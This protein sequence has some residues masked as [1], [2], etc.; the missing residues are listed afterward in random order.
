[1]IQAGD[2]IC[3]RG[4]GWL[5]DKIRALTRHIGE[6]RTQISHVAIGVD[7]DTVVE[8]LSKVRQGGLQTD[9][10]VAI[11]RPKGLT[12]DEIAVIVKDAK[13]YVGRSY[14]YIKIAAHALDWLLQGA[15]VFRRLTQVDNYP[16]CSW[17]VAKAYAA[18]GHTFGVDAGAASPDDI[19]DYV[20]KHPEQFHMVRELKPLY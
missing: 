7:E 5:S 3:V 4:K 14:G 19:W 1:M 15:Y 8:A 18:A 20:T 11:F 10:D 2:V 12:P 13:S 17:V 6:S 9:G 16:I